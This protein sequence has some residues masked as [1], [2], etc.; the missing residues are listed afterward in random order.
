MAGVT[1]HGVAH[2][3]SGECATEV[4]MLRPV[5]QLFS[6]RVRN[7]NGCFKGHA[8]RRRAK[9]TA[10]NICG[11][12]CA[13][14]RNSGAAEKR[15]SPFWS[16][17]PILEREIASPKTAKVY[18]KYQ[19]SVGNMVFPDLSDTKWPI[20]KRGSNRYLSRTGITKVT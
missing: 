18:L 1:G 13:D 6:V 8:G 16:C 7:G 20:V 11:A 2:L 15:N 17:F 14:S 5:A 9:R 12:N 4:D 19:D 3:L 10:R